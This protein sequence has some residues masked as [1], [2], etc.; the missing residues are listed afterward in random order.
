MKQLNQ[1]IQEPIV[2]FEVAKLLK[3]KG[4]DCNAKF[5]YN[6]TYEPHHLNLIEFGYLQICVVAVNYY[7]T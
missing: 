2:S 5:G 4:F 3:E 6:S 1:N 7:K